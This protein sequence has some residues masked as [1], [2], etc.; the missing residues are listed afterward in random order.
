MDKAI[1]ADGTAIAFERT[2]EGAPVILVG[3]ALCDRG[4]TRPLAEALS[5]DFTV[6]GYDRRGRGDS[7][8]TAPYAVEREIEDLEAVLEA[9]GGTASVYGHSSGAALVLHAVAH[10]LVF[11]KVIL[12]EPPFNPDTEENRQRAESLAADIAAS[13]AQD[14]NGDALT[15][16]LTTT[17]M[18]PHVAAQMSGVPGLLALA[19][20]LPHDLAVVGRSGSGESLTAPSLLV[21]GGASGPQMTETARRIAD[22][23]PDGRFVLLEG[24]GHGVPPEVL[25]PVVAEFFTAG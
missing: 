10:G 19:P 9:A 14:R 7:G 3:G 24:Q 11:D 5:R 13:L 23:A 1:S 18:P 20:T 16:F 8:N 22:E 4:S 15:A 6:F 2:G 21:A 12:H 17:G 25:A